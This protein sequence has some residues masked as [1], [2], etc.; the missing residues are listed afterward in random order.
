[1]MGLKGEMVSS[2]SITPFIYVTLTFVVV[3][4]I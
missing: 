2:K 1:M 4:N 3:Y